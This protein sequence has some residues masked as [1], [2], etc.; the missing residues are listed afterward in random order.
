MLPGQIPT[1][2]IFSVLITLM[3]TFVSETMA[4][5]YLILG[6]G[7]APYVVLC[8]LCKGSPAVA[9]V[10]GA[11]LLGPLLLMSPHWLHILTITVTPF[12]TSPSS[13]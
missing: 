9:A 11:D 10:M 4:N 6:N 2:Q 1:R 13:S 8:F 5:K 3:S 7:S 12:I